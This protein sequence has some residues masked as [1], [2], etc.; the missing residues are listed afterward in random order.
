MA[1]ENPDYVSPRKLPKLSKNFSDMISP[2]HSQQNY[3]SPSFPRAP[4]SYYMPS[5]I[6]H[7]PNQPQP[8]HQHIGYD[9]M[10][11]LAAQY[12]IAS[13]PFLRSGIFIIHYGYKIAL[14]YYIV[15]FLLMLMF[16]LI[17]QSY[18]SSPPD[19]SYNPKKY[20][21]KYSDNY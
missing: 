11:A 14:I 16:M 18:M 9:R 12:M 6:P 19:I 4:P 13:D 17:A 10:A 21:N 2:Y 8:Q 15:V 7:L 3:F 5:E 1:N 20:D